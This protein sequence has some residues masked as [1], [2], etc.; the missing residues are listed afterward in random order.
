MCI[1]I[2][3]RSVC[4]AS[5]DK[6]SLNNPFLSSKSND[7]TFSISDHKSVRNGKQWPVE[8]HKTLKDLKCGS[9]KHAASESGKTQIRC[10][11]IRTSTECRYFSTSI[12]IYHLVTLLICS[13]ISSNGRSATF[14]LSRRAFCLLPALIFILSPFYYYSISSRIFLTVYWT[15]CFRIVA[16]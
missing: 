7:K 14:K 3:C 13:T 2:L 15:V 12:L 9:D 4:E 10:G 16:V 5:R 1:K 8:S 11:Q 6:H